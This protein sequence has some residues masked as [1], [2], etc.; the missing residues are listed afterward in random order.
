MRPVRTLL[1]FA[2][3]SDNQ[4]FSYQHGWPRHFRAHPG[5]ICTPV[6]LA[7]RS[8]ANR[9]AHPLRVRWG[10]WDAIVL[11]HS[12]FSNACALSGR[13]FEAIRASPSPKAYFIGNE[14]KLM[15]EKMAFCE[16][17]GVNLL[18]SQSGSP[19]VHDLYRERLGCT[20]TGIPNTGLD[21]EVFR[22]RTPWV[23]RPLDVGYRSLD[24]PLYLGHDERR[25][26]AEAFRR[27]GPSRGLKV[28]ISLDAGARLGETEWAAFL[29]RCKAQIGSE[30][31]GDYFELT[32]AT[33]L[34]VNAYL[35]EHPT[36]TL[37]DVF[38]RFFKDYRDPVPL[39]II[40]GRNIEAAGTKTLQ[41]L[42][43][44][45]YGGYLEPHVHYIPLRKDLSNVDEALQGLRDEAACRKLT[46]NAYD[47]V[48]RELTYARLL[49][50]FQVALAALL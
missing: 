20:V 43:E 44:G 11:L 41:I 27:A 23:E 10:S 42:L 2:E 19:R 28:D 18:V 13:L 49:D 29:N 26:L 24:S 35:A 40:S 25:R 22:P 48:V 17:L 33:R 5:F 12:V 3:S 14:Y 8:W 7:G 6:N 50:R 1:V 9:L 16:A 32:D 37:D 34:R 21:P 46:D 39:R 15:P 4:T 31:G 45:H 47:L 30:A 38:P 36:A